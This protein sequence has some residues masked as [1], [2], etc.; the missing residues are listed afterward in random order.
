MSLSLSVST[1]E[2]I[3]GRELWLER[4]SA[5]SLVPRDINIALGSNPEQHAHLPGLWQ[6]RAVD[7]N[8]TLSILTGLTMVATY[9][10]PIPPSPVLPLS[11]A[12]SPLR[13]F[14]TVSNF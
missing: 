9:V 3:N 10:T 1:S 7:I 13:F 2:A 11:T 6:N 4:G 12:H 14:S 8:M 5:S